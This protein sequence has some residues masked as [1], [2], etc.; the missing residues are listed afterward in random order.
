MKIAR[1][2]VLVGV[3]EEAR[4]AGVDRVLATLREKLAEL[5]LADEVQVVET[6]TLGLSGQ[7]V[8]LVVYPEGVYYAGVT[9]EAAAEIVEEHL[10]KGRPVEKLRLPAPAAIGAADPGGAAELRA[11]RSGGDRGLHRHR[12][13]RGPGP[14]APAPAGGADPG[15]QG[16]R[17]QGAGPA[18]PPGSSGKRWP[19]PEGR[20]NT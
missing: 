4:L 19:A 12:G 3:D 5:G 9:P 6:G 14:G 7:G 13:V 11:N 2:H 15:D 1:A 10:L 18:S 20:K 16:R 17:A 8:V